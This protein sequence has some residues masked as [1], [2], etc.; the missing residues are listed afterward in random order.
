MNNVSFPGLGLFFEFDNVAIKIGSINIYWYA[1]FI[2]AAFSIGLILCKMD[3]GKYGIKFENIFE[4]FLFVLPS[5]II[6]ARIYYVIFHLEPYIANLLDVFNLRNGGLAIY[7]GIIGAVVCLVIYCKIKKINILDMLDFC[8]P[9]LPL[10]QAIGRWGNF[11]NVEAYGYET[12]SFLRMGITQNGT[13][14]E[15]HPTFLY[16]S[17]LNFLIFILLFCLRKKRKFKGQMVCIYLLLYGIVRFFVEGLRTDSL[18]LGP[19]R[20]SQAL[21]LV[22]AI[23]GGV[24]LIVKLKKKLR[25]N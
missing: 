9:M 20:V 21:S 18:M 13:Y 22:L 15:V 11:F 16:E 5:A 10:G 4:A 1:I 12:D 14:M 8:T 24:V 19:L 25:N 23:V 7:G 2:I 3:N 6:G 17:V